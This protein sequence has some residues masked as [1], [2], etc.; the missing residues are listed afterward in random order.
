LT[1]DWIR[2][3]IAGDLET[4]RLNWLSDSNGESEHSSLSSS[5]SANGDELEDEFD[6]TTPTLKTFIQRRDRARGLFEPVRHRRQPSTDTITQEAFH[7]PVVTMAVTSESPMEEMAELKSVKSAG[8]VASDE[9]RPSAAG[10]PLPAPPAQDTE[11]FTWKAAALPAAIVPEPLKATTPPINP[12][13][14]KKV[15]WKAGKNI[16]VLLPMDEGRGQ[17]GKA[18]KPMKQQEVEAMHRDWEQLGYNVKGFN[19]GFVDESSAEGEGQSRAVWPDNTDTLHERSLRNFRVSIPDRRQWDAYVKELSEAKLRALGV[20]FG[21]EDPVPTISPAAS[22][23]SRQTSMQ[24]P[25]LPFSPPIPTSSAGSSRA[26]HHHG[27]KSVFSPMMMSGAGLSTSQSSIV[28]SIAS[29]ASM[30]AQS[31]AKYNPRASMSMASGEHPFGS[32]F[33]YAHQASP[34]MWSPQ[35]MIYQPGLARGG[36]PSIS[37]LGA[38]MSP[39]SP[40]SQDG[41]FP[42]N[43]LGIQLQQ[44]QQSL[45]NQLQQQM[46]LQTSARQSPRLQELREDDLETIRK[47]PSKTPEPFSFPSKLNESESLQ[48]EIDDA[49]YHLEE[50]FQRQL[51]HD[52]Y[53]PHSDKDEHMELP[54]V[55]IKSH[56]RG[57]SSIATALGGSRFASDA[58]EGP[59][60][61]HPQP[62]SRDHSLSQRPFDEEAMKITLGPIGEGGKTDQS[63]A[64]NGQSGFATPELTS[65]K[66]HQKS[67]SSVTNPWADSDNGSNKDTAPKRPGHSAKPSISKLNVSAPEFKFNPSNSFQ[68]SQFS[69]SGASFQPSAAAAPAFVPSNSL[70]KSVGSSFAFGSKIN[71]DAPA[72]TPGQSDFSFSSSGPSFRPDAPAFTPL[73]TVSVDSVGSGQS[74]TEDSANAQSSI[75][76]KIDLNMASIIKPS[77]KSKAI[78]IIRPDSSAGAIGSED[79][80]MEGGDG[81]ITQGEGRIKRARGVG[82]EGDSVPLFAEPS[83]PLQ[84]TSREQSPPKDTMPLSAKQADKENLPA[85][86][87]EEAI[88]AQPAIQKL[89]KNRSVL[90]DSPDYEGRGWAPWELDQQDHVQ[91]FSSAAAFPVRGPGSF[92]VEEKPAVPEP[93]KKQ[94]KKNSLSALAIPFSPSWLFGSGNAAAAATSASPAISAPIPSAGLSSSRYASTPPPPPKTVDEPLEVALEPEEIESFQAALPS[95]QSPPAYNDQPS[96]T[97]ERLLS[98]EEIDDVMR[99]MN[100][101]DHRDADT[102][103]WHQPSPMRTVQIPEVESSPIRLNPQNLMRSDAPSPSPRR[104]QA[105][106]GEPSPH[107][108]FSRVHDDP[109]VESSMG[110]FDSPIHRLNRGTSMPASDWDDVLS[111]QEEDKFQAR[112]QFFDHHV[113][114]IVGGVLAERLD[115]LE[116]VL[117]TIQLS[118]ANMSGRRISSH[119]DRRSTSELPESDADDEDDEEVQQRSLSPR[120]DRKLEKIRNIVTEALAAHRRS[121]SPVPE[122]AVSQDSNVLQVLEEMRDQFGQSMRLDLRAEDLR[123]IVEEAVERRMPASPKPLLDEAAN[124]K[125]ADLEAKISELNVRLQSNDTKA[126]EEIKNRRAA[127]D[128]LA[129]VQRLL[130]I[131]SEEETRL[132]EALDEKEQKL[133][134]LEDSRSKNHMRSTLLEAN[135]ENAQKNQTELSNRLNLAENEL[136]Q[137][138]QQ[139][140][141]WQAEAERAMEIAKRH[142][143]D[144][145]RA[146]ETNSGLRIAVERVRLQVEESLHVRESMRAKLA[147]LQN[148]MA[149]A[150]HEV[151]QENFRRAKKEQQLIARQEV[152]DARLQAE[153]RTRERLEREIERLEDGE[154]EGMRAVNESKRLETLLLS[155]RNELHESQKNSMRYQRE[156]EEARESGLSEVQ[157]TRHYMQAEIEAAN[158]QVNIV[159]QELEDQVARVRAEIDHVKLDADTVK[160][161]NEMLLEEATELKQKEL[162]ALI[163]RHENAIEDLQTR[164][165][166]QLGNTMEDAARSEQQLLERLSLS[167]AKT[168]H[169]QDRVA[170]LEEKLEIAKEAALAAAQSARSLPA[171]TVSRTA[172]LP[173]R[174]SPQALRESIMVLQ[175]QLQDREQTIEILEQQLSTVDLD[176][177]TKITKRDD[178][179]TWLRELLAVRVGDLQ[180]II[181]TVSQDGFNPENVKDAAIRLKA[182]LQMEQQERERAM[183]GGSAINIAATIKEVATGPRVAQVIGPMAAAWGNWRKSQVGSLSE[184]ISN[185]STP[186]KGTLGAQSYLSGLMTPPASTRTPTQPT[187]FGN[188]GRR[189]TAQQLA[190][191]PSPRREEQMKVPTTPPMMRKGS[192]DRDAQAEDFSDAGFYDDDES[193]VDDAMFA[194]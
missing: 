140:Q 29:P 146:N 117:E 48:K 103:R 84:E 187:A 34:G 163:R 4:E 194:R 64:E 85:D 123:T 139:A 68:P 102:P 176:A 134:T 129:E 159:R 192:Y 52:D 78:P 46:H 125:A 114:E 56:T 6:P 40:F 65:S 162:D 51:E 36:S 5:N 127:E 150:A 130:R 111:E 99:H 11:S 145:E 179:I 8:T 108:D 25:A 23:M 47:S 2:Q 193:T 92:D 172:D 173:E 153:A 88:A 67:Y 122:R 144:A 82:R 104:F 61:H 177:P 189:F 96:G 131:S 83:Q 156:F 19:L 133:K 148:G 15:P 190:N 98:F 79:E 110:A 106:P 128:R 10:K 9:Q 26:T 74:S 97:E 62:H 33:Q 37:N 39:S 171:K 66:I 141:H 137:A 55:P 164:H 72:F 20:S 154:R 22:N 113:N 30:H 143:D 87:E 175:E 53:S 58:R 35:S 101:V 109:F 142:N 126:E 93:A 118:I 188:T 167:S 181:N 28:G 3:H 59:Q 149:A 7:N 81:R 168:E 24:Y 151:Q 186:S 157:R 31:F 119:H 80:T 16:L 152:L 12:R 60:L 115:P 166:R 184:M 50:Q 75:F 183:N 191:R 138:R 180:D 57:V 135:A 18:P 21:D 112:T 107:R 155:L 54:V 42:Q 43:D 89:A 90:E 174:I 124:A 70:H 77:K 116:R 44:R 45:Q 185:G 100:E 38:I 76:G 147:G 105:L 14:K 27:S 63:E 182:N 136:R 17:R 178:E 95:P 165:K 94:H 49:E 69:F 73:Q 169:L 161:K 121:V 170:H 91:D 71:V 86:G 32:P 13:L 1:E 158:N 120:K 41:Y 160:A 132:R